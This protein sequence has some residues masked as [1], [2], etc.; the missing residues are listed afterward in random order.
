M[1]I[2]V[3]ERCGRTGYGVGVT[4]EEYGTAYYIFS[5]GRYRLDDVDWHS[6]GDTDEDGD[7]ECVECG[8]N[9]MTDFDIPIDYVN[10]LLNEVDDELRFDACAMLEAG[11]TPEEV[12]EELYGETH[13]EE[14]PKTD[15][16]PRKQGS[17][18]LELRQ[19]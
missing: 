18:I 11:N 1:I 15:E 19:G 13:E 9:S 6:G 5:N 10:F 16:L 3:C 4:R 8:T 14:T 12:R 2:Y 7:I 17:T